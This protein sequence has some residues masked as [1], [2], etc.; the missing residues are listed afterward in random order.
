MTDWAKDPTTRGHYKSY[1]FR[2][3][4]RFLHLATFSFTWRLPNAFW[5]MAL[6]FHAIKYCLFLAFWFI[7]AWTGTKIVIGIPVVSVFYW[8]LFR[9]ALGPTCKERLKLSKIAIIKHI[10]SE[11]TTNAGTLSCMKLRARNANL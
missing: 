11:L 9:D 3:L 8:V 6:A 5:W 10:D 4:I 2:L 1:T 7:W